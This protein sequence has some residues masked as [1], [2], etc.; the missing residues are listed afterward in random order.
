MSKQ[1]DIFFVS[2]TNVA[3]HRR[4]GASICS[5]AYLQAIA[6]AAPGRV[7][8][9]S[10]CRREELLEL[11]DGVDEVVQLPR[12]SLSDKVFTLLAGRAADRLSPFVDRLLRSRDLSRALFF[13]NFS[14]G[15]RFSRW[16]A[17]RGVP[18]ITLFHNVEEQYVSA[19]VRTPVLRQL[20]LRAADRNDRDA[21]E[22]SAASIFLSDFDADTMLQR[23]RQRQPDARL[24]RNGYFSP[25]PHAG[26]PGP[27]PSP[28]GRDFIIAC[29]LGV[30]QNISGILRFI[31]EDWRK[32]VAD[33]RLV[34]SKLI[35]AGASPSPAIV[36]ACRSQPRI[37]LVSSP[38]DSAMRELMARSIACISTIDA[39][40]G[41]KVRVAEALRLGRPVVGTAHSFIGYER[42][43]PRVRIVAEI[44]AMHPRLAD[45]ATDPQVAGL[46]TLA[47]AEFAAKL[48]YS[49]GA[50]WVRELVSSLR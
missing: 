11:P 29:H 44:G 41:I 13:M 46:C 17:D 40:S 34:G 26:D 39:G 1:R 31:D 12:R 10:P 36:A 49:H 2:P 8:L 30:A 47:S 50:S 38:T 6:A 5:L 7:V 15:G 43:D 23:S 9:V 24:V 33:G 28:S 35:I 18:S 32:C 45:L 3:D 37:D 20:R 16:L 25:K 48:S 19:S 42:I 21:F 27:L 4:G 14:R 22:C